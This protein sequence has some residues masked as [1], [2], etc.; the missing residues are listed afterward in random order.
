MNAH[1]GTSE[2][3]AWKG[4]EQPEL[5]DMGSAQASARGESKCLRAF[6]VTPII[7]STQLHFSL[8]V[9]QCSFPGVH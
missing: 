3:S 1:Q 2:Q 7:G 5:R 4:V 8:L 6:A 9:S